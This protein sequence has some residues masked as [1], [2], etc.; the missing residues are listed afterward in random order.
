M[1]DMMT[2]A[3][4]G[5]VAEADTAQTLMR[6]A[7]AAQV[8]RACDARG[9]LALLVYLVL[10]SV[11]FGRVLFGRFSTFCIGTGPDPR[12]MMWFLMWWPHALAHG[13]DPFSDQSHVGA[14]WDQSIVAYYYASRCATRQSNN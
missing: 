5:A 1:V 7:K 11:F 12:A 2:A 9:L 10:S 3:R 8:I 14:V 13:L 4:T 6:S